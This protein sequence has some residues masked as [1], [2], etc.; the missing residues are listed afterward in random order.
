VIVAE[1][2]FLP[3]MTK[4]ELSWC[5]ATPNRLHHGDLL[6]WRASRLAPDFR[7]PEGDEWN[8]PKIKSRAS[9]MG[10][11]LSAGLKIT[12]PAL[13]GITERPHQGDSGIHQYNV[14]LRFRALLQSTRGFSQLS[15]PFWVVQSTTKLK[16][17]N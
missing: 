13:S 9:C 14:R 10:G 16:R 4:A 12:S 15:S 2:P 7:K 3:P 11:R 17:R 5:N 1:F 8:E 6:L